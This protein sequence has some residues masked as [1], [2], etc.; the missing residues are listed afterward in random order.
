MGFGVWLIGYTAGFY[1]ITLPDYP[2]VM[3][4]PATLLGFG[5]VAGLVTTGLAWW[6]LRGRGP[7]SWRYALA[8]GA[9]WLGVAVVCDFLFIVL[10]FHAWSY[11]RLDIG[12]YYAVTL[13]APVIGA[14][15]AR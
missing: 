3:Q 2:A 15:L 9:S 5:L 6:R 7:I 8:V 1:I 4:Q 11:Y 12:V 10:L 13:V 14:R